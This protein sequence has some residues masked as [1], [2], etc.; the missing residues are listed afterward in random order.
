MMGAR[1]GRLQLQLDG[2]GIKQASFGNFCSRHVKDDVNAK[3]QEVRKD[4]S[5]WVFNLFL[6]FI[7]TKQQ[8]M[9]KS[10]QQK[11]EHLA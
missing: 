4:T 3:R 6:S 11:F 9:E 7:F 2:R 1:A 10:P 5:P 8:E